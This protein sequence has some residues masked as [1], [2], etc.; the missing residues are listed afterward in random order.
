MVLA[1]YVEDGVARQR[2]IARLQ[3]LLQAGLGVLERLR[4]GQRCD[5]RR[6]QPRDHPLHGGESAIEKQRPAD[7]F[8]CVGEDRLTAK[9]PAAQLAGAELQGLTEAQRESHLGE[10]LAAHQPGAQAAQVPFRCLGEGRIQL[11]RD[12]QIEDGV[13]EKLEPLVVGA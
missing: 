5:A 10:R 2:K 3:V 1:F 4:L 12:D 13:T 8:Q 6:E 11:V 9:A 7:R